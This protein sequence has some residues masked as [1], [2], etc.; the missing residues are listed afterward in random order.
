MGKSKI[1]CNSNLL[2]IQ[3]N[4]WAWNQDLKKISGF[5][6][7]LFYLISLHCKEVIPVVALFSYLHSF[8]LALNVSEGQ[9]GDDDDDVS[10]MLVS[11]RWWVG[12]SMQMQ[13]HSPPPTLLSYYNILP[14]MQLCRYH[15]DG[16]HA[17]STDLS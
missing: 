16:D 14:N 10:D 11:K 2:T 5:L 15:E 1:W 3:S 4:F 8:S 7:Q 17:C 9:N 6:C 13:S 12:G